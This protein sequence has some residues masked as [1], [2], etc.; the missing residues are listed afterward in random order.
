MLNFGPAGFSADGKAS[1]ERSE[2]EEEV[3]D[4]SC[5]TI[6]IA[7]LVFTVG[8]GWQMATYNNYV[9]SMEEH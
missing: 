7:S 3:L 4:Q 6:T 1:A 9:T 8:D 5:C 2:E